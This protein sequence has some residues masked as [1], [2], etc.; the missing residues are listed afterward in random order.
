MAANPVAD[1]IVASVKSQHLTLELFRQQVAAFFVDNPKLRQGNPAIV[2]SVKSRMKS[3]ESIRSKIERK[4]ADGENIDATNAFFKITDFA[5]VRVLH[6]LQDQFSEIHDAISQHLGQG[7]WVLA[8][9]PKAYT[10]DPDAE[11]Y[12]KSLGLNT[13]LKESRYTSVHYVV[14]PRAESIASC[15]IQVRTLWE[16]IW[17]EV[18]HAINYPTECKVLSCVEQI[19]VLA[20][21]VAT[22][23]RLGDS[24]F[25]CYSE[26]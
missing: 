22:G 17:G 2:H 3:E 6:L 23:T 26:K 7:E 8:E 18:D 20:R 19:R 13:E 21:L 25:K 14:K 9:P 16:E 15:E 12:F 11:A 10:W 1:A 24:I 5:G 4:L